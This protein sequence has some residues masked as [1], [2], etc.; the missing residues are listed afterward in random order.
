MKVID[1]FFLFWTLIATGFLILSLLNRRLRSHFIPGRR[2][3]R[4]QQ[5]A[6]DR[7]IKAF[8]Q[9]ESAEIWNKPAPDAYSILG[10]SLGASQKEIGKAFKRRIK[11][12]HPD[13]VAHLGE[14]YV[15]IAKDR[16][17][18]ITNA[19]DELLKKFNR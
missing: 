12:Y 14:M 10:V 7:R 1:F 11:E 18:M 9:Q 19:R 5:E 2:R 13:R 15:R 4:K 16:T 8:Y 17:I 3:T 6:D